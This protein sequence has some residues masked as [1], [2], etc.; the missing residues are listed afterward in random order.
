MALP[1]LS[2]PT[3]SG[4]GGGPW[5]WGASRGARSS[6]EQGN[7]QGAGRTRQLGLQQDAGSFCLCG[8]P[9]IPVP[10]AG[11]S[12]REVPPASPGAAQRKGAGSS[13][14]RVGGPCLA[15]LPPA[16]FLEA[17]PPGPLPQLPGAAAGRAAAAGKHIQYGCLGK[18]IKARIKEPNTA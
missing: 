18:H 9:H 5:L 6:P 2:G 11:A 14:S 16:G 3:P 13:V 15:P 7:R 12:E 1:S 10:G 17:R 8:F 4:A